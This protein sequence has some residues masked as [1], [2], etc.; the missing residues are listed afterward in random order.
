MLRVLLVMI[1]CRAKRSDVVGETGTLVCTI[2]PATGSRKVRPLRYIVRVALPPPATS[3]DASICSTSLVMRV[4]MFN[5]IPDLT[6]V[7]SV[8]GG[9]ISLLGFV[10]AVNA[11]FCRLNLTLHHFE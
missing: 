5:I 7:G 1:L 6:V 4:N 3:W 8:S 10:S 2:L 9:G 11:L